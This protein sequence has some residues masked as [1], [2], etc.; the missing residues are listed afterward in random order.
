MSIL[1]KV[2]E[3]SLKDLNESGIV[4]G[5]HCWLIY[6]MKGK[7]YW[8]LNGICVNLKEILK[9]DDIEVIYG[10][11]DNCGFFTRLQG[12][13]LSLES[14]ASIIKENKENIMSNFVEEGRE[15][16]FSSIDVV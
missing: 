4:D 12:H 7:L 5:Q 9:L 2:E 16:R 11:N 3:V 1:N 13:N 15:L 6:E 14:L 10:Y 8:D